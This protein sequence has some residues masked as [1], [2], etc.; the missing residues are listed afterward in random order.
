MNGKSA[1]EIAK[2]LDAAGAD[3]LAPIPPG[4]ARP[5]TDPEA[6]AR[7]RAMHADPIIESE[8]N[9]LATEWIRR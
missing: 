2:A 8:Y 4:E 3:G 1:S 6:V 9:P 5:L 7:W